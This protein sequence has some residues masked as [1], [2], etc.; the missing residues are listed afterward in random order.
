MPDQLP[1]FVSSLSK[2]IRVE[3]YYD[4]LASI[5]HDSP[6]SVLRNRVDVFS[7]NTRKK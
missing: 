2:Y 4:L 6:E 1:Q 3:K 5:S 7:I